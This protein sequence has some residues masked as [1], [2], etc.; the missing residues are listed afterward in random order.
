MRLCPAH[1][2]QWLEARGVIVLKERSCGLKRN[3]M[4]V[5]RDQVNTWHVVCQTQRTHTCVLRHNRVLR[6]KTIAC[7]IKLLISRSLAL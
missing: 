2:K 3:H 5:G 6:H 4:A 7:L 1:R